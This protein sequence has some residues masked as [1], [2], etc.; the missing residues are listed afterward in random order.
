MGHV[1]PTLALYLT[2]SAPSKTIATAISIC[3]AQALY[4]PIDSTTNHDISAEDCSERLLL[5][6]AVGSKPSL[7]VD[8]INIEQKQSLALICLAPMAYLDD[9]SRVFTM[10]FRVSLA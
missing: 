5:A 10:I 3:N 6:D 9:G 2:T 7:L 8:T 1:N 4:A